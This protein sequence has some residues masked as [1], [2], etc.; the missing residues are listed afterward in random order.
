[1]DKKIFELFCIKNGFPKYFVKYLKSF[2]NLE[3][4]S[5]MI[6]FCKSN[7]L[8]NNL[9]KCF[10][11]IIVNQLVYKSLN[12]ECLIFSVCYFWLYKKSF[13]QNFCLIKK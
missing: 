5:E 1:M 13:L 8:M 4:I 12:G 6:N 10:S 2:K 3:M 7:F 9:T 11:G